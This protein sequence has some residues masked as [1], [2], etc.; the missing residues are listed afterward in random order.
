MAPSDT[1]ALIP[2][3]VLGK[4]SQPRE[5]KWDTFVEY[6]ECVS[7]TSDKKSE[8]IFFDKPNKKIVKRLKPL[9]IK[10]T[11]NGKV[12]NQVIVDGATNFNVMPILTMKKL[13][14]NTEDLITTN[15]KMTNIM[16]VASISLR[17]P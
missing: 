6:T 10:A 7:L 2:P 8:G 5:L 9:F 15:M 14:K 11:I 3:W 16:G 12:F 17:S 1:V 4:V 13:G